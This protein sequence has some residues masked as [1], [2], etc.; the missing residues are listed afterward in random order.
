MARDSDRP[1][2]TTGTATRVVKDATCTFCG[3]LCD[4]IELTVTGDRITEAVNACALGRT[5]FLD[6]RA[7]D[8]RPEALIGG[9]PAPVERALDEAAAVLRAAHSPLVYGLSD[10]TV[11]AQRAAVEIADLLGACL[12]S[13]TSL[14]HGSSLVAM[15]TVGKVTC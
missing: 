1:L 14:R 7:D 9:A 6:Q 11:E 2:M 3:C 4:D 15:Q 10:T 13:E 8:S 12:D 5:W